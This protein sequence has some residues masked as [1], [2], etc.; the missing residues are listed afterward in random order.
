MTSM[1]QNLATPTHARTVSTEGRTLPL[2]GSALDVDAS[3]GLA[4]VV[5]TQ[6]FTNPHAEPLHVTYKLPLPADAAVGG[7]A[8]EIAGKRSVGRVETK[9]K[10]RET[11]EEAILQGKTAALLE[12]ETSSLFTQELGN[13]PPG[14]EVRVEVTLD[15]PL[16]WLSGGA[17]EGSWEFRFPLTLAPRYL[18]GNGSTASEASLAPLVIDVASAPIAARASLS[19]RIRDALT[20]SRSPESP[21]HPLQTR[22]AFGAYQVELGS[23]NKAELDRDV[24]VRWPVSA[25]KPKIAL[26]ACVVRQ[27]GSGA[28]FGLLSLVPPSL[29]LSPGKVKRD[30]TLLLDTS[31]S[32]QGSPLDQAKRIASAIV[33]SLD[34]GD[35]FELIEFGND[36]NPYKKGSRSATKAERAEAVK[37]IQRR[38]ASG[39]TEMLSGVKA[40][41]ASLG[42]GAQRQIVLITDGLIGEEGRIVG[43]LANGLPRSSRFHAVGVGAAANRSL[44]MPIARAGRGAEAIVGIGEDAEPAVA[45]LLRR[46]SSPI[47]VDLAIEGSALRGVAPERLPDLFAGSPARIPVALSREG[48]EIVITG[49]THEGPFTDRIVVDADASDEPSGSDALARLYARER[50][51]DLELDLAIGKAKPAIDAEIERLGLAHQIATRLTSFVAVSDEVTVAP[52]SATRRET[53]PHVLPQGMSAEGVGLSAPLPA[54]A[55]R[56]MAASMAMP[57]V[58]APAPAGPP[59]MRAPM[60]PVRAEESRASAGGAVRRRAK[61]DTGDYAESAK[62]KKAIASADDAPAMHAPEPMPEAVEEAPKRESPSL[63]GRIKEA[64]LGD[65][66]RDEETRLP[67][68]AAKAKP[69]AMEEPAEKGAAPRDEVEARSKRRAPWIAKILQRIGERLVLELIVPEDGVEFTLFGASMQVQFTDGTRA[70]VTFDEKSTTRAG[71]YAKGQVLRI[72]LLVGRDAADVEEARVTLEHAEITAR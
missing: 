42:S 9:K 47:V 69:L 16:A 43:A 24:V 10:A 11:F 46:M 66:D 4:R 40:A 72:V 58:P 52:T 8:F 37:W 60:K 48:G 14:G 61:A 55:A 32:M 22:E 59:A 35:A 29:A 2:L 44:L 13:V 33:D 34:E 28:R 27:G 39:G 62:D 31:G 57:K 30:V 64:F 15:C 68:G 63:W 51:E 20:P 38:V 36:A 6:R 3:G 25:A 54:I 21:S 67:A 23:G 41:L 5:F 49:R 17:S 19:M 7:F 45:R 50:V 53:Q 12:S 70:E 18:G 26:D 56:P 65:A 71:T 1:L